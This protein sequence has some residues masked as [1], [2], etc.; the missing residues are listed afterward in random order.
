MWI[1]T[2]FGQFVLLIVRLASNSICAKDSSTLL[3][4]F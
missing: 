4:D 1:L 3:F 2:D